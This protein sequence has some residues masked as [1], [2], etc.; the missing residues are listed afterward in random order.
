MM[1]V[2]RDNSEELDESLASYGYDMDYIDPQGG[3]SQL[4]FNN[5]LC[6]NGEPDLQRLMTGSE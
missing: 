2:P 5:Y 6:F 1:M 4:D 3:S